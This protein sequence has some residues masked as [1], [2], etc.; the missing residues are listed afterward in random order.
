MPRSLFALL[1]LPLVAVADAVADAPPKP[2]GPKPLPIAELKRTTPIA[3][4]KEILP[5][6]AAKCQACHAGKVIEGKLDLSTYASMMKGGETVGGVIAAGKADDSRLFQL[7]AH[8][9]KPIMPPKND[10]DP[11]TADELALLKLWIDQGAK[12]PAVDAKVKRTVTLSLPPA[13]V[14]PVRAVAIHPTAPVVAAGRGNQ[15]HLFDAKT[16]EFKA[17]LTDPELKLPDGKPATAA[18]ISLVES[19]AYSPDGKTLASGSFQEVT[20]WDTEKGTPKARVGGFAD[21]VV[22][23]AFAA[24]GKT[25]AT[26]GGAPTEDGELKLFDAAGKPITEVKNAHS[27]TVF[28][29]SFSPDGKLLAS[30]GADKFVKV[31]E[32]P[33]G[34]LVKTFEGHTNHVLDVG[35]TADGKKLVSCGADADKM[36][37]VWDYEKGEKV[38]DM[39]THKNQTSRLVF[40]PKSANFITCGGDGGSNLWNA[41]NGGNQR[42][43]AGAKDFLYAVAVSA[44]GKTVA[45]GGEEGVVRLFN[46]ENGNLIKE[47][48][49]PGVEAKKPDP[50]KK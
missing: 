40:V 41:D 15:I 36:V 11:M 4:D 17:T 3:F 14:K 1:L 45:H 48:L 20:L 8:K 38:R 39:T 5:I 47:L 10:G 27:D 23:I 46:G 30:G 12:P 34:K 2:A 43:F 28:G 7:S 29:V 16:G 44:D 21:R 19:L 50:M 22:A 9:L 33:A 24:D 26:G 18:H 32:V 42:A 25:F 13:V 31:F 37:K 35:W 6:L 49:P